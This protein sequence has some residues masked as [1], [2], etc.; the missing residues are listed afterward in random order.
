MSTDFNT[1]AQTMFGATTPSSQTDF[2]A[3]LRDQLA[4]I[5]P[6]PDLPEQAP[7]SD[8][9][10]A[11]R[12]FGDSDPVL[13]YG[14]AARDIESA[15]LESL[16]DPEEAASTATQWASEFQT[17]G[18]THAESVTLTEVGIAAVTSAPSAETVLTWQE[19]ARTALLQDFGPKGAA[20]ALAD[21]QTF[22]TRFGSPELRDVL[23]M[24]G[25]GNHPRV[26][27]V[28][29]AKARAARLEGR[30]R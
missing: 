22:V 8:E 19:D 1:M 5:T 28:I 30:L 3:D 14:D 17:L 2:G 25:L 20:Q 6:T 11:E 13:T 10:H 27:R 26:V 12:M 29:A 15:V 9:E 18:L 24:T 16:G 23:N 21:A 7:L 4:G